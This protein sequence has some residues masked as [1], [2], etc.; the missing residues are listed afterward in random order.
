MEYIHLIQNGKSKMADICNSFFNNN[1][2]RHHDI[3]SIVKDFWCDSQIT[4]L[5]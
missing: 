5:C 2:W 3:N 4:S 1:K